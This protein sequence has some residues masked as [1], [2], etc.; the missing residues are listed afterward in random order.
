MHS[1]N[2]PKI[3]FSLYAESRLSS[4][5]YSP[6]AESI[7]LSPQH[8]AQMLRK[9][10]HAYHDAFIFQHNGVGNQKYQITIPTDVVEGIHQEIAYQSTIEQQDQELA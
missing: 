8:W 5:H 9:R 1:I 7:L 4:D 6:H 2:L 10:C 3:Y